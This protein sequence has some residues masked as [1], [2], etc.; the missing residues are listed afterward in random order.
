MTPLGP[1]MPPSPHA[2]QRQHSALFTAVTSRFGKR[3]RLNE[4]RFKLFWETM[5]VATSMLMFTALRPST[6]ATTADDTGQSTRIYLKSEALGRTDLKTRLQATEVSDAAGPH[7]SMAKDFTI[8]SKSRVH[9][10]STMRKSDVTDAA[11]GNVIPIRVV[12]N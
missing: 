3:R 2:K 8:H 6:T 11:K 10:T 9:S 5:A 7:Y 4:P 12:Y 1:F